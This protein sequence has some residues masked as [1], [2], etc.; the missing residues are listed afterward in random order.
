MLRTDHA[1]WAAPEIGVLLYVQH[2]GETIGG[3]RHR[4][5]AEILILS[6]HGVA[7]TWCTVHI[8]KVRNTKHKIFIQK[9]IL[10][11]RSDHVSKYACLLAYLL[12]LEPPPGLFIMLQKLF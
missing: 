8:S 5:L 7:I 12:V 6:V 3:P 4:G 9:V 1:D 11:T 2:Q 10:Q